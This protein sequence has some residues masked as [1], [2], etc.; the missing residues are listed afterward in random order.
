MRW[1]VCDVHG[2]CVNASF[3]AANTD[4]FQRSRPV[5][6]FRRRV[7]SDQGVGTISY[8]HAYTAMQ[9]LLS[10]ALCLVLNARIGRSGTLMAI[11]PLTM[12][13]VCFVS[14][15]GGIPRRD[16]VRNLRFGFEAAVHVCLGFSWIRT[17][18]EPFARR[19]RH[20]LGISA[21][22]RQ[23]R[24]FGRLVSGRW[25]IGTDAAVV[26]TTGLHEF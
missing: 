7:L 26:R 1:R 15:L 19:S 25:A 9:V 5:G 6:L 21:G 2:G 3:C 16:L 23:T 18:Y 12:I 20:A 17:Y 4:R 8:N 14:G 24:F 11:V 10:G 13:F 22:H